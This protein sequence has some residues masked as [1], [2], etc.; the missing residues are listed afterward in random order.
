[1]E[2]RLSKRALQDLESIFLY[3]EEEW[4]VNQRIK[5]A[6]QLKLVLKFLEMYPNCGQ[7]TKRSGVS[8]LAV[9]KLPFVFLFKVTNSNLVVI[10]VLH[11]KQRK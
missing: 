1:M 6:L 4:G 11:S 8:A 5:V 3:T 7:T 9:P 10:Q 2:V